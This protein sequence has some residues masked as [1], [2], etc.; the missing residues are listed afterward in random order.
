MNKVL[1][2]ILVLLICTS[3]YS[4]SNTESKDKKDKKGYV[5]IFS[6]FRGT[7]TL[8]GL[9]LEGVKLTRT[10]PEIGK[11]DE[12]TETIYTDTNGYYEFEE[13][14]GK[15]GIMRFLP[16][17]AVIHQSIKAYYE[18]KEYLLW[19]TCKRNYEPLGELKYY[20]MEPILNK[21]MS[22]AYKEDYILVNGDLESSEDFV[23]SVN[24]DI[25]FISI[26][27]FKFPYELAL[28]E[29]AQVLAAREYEFTKEISSWFEH[30]P[31]F[32][33]QLSDGSWGDMELENLEPYIGVVIESV[34]TVDYSDHLKL[35]YFEEDNNKEFNRVTVSGGIILNV[36]D[37]KGKHIKARVWLSSAIFKVYKDRVILEVQD[38][39]F[40]I[41]SSNIDP[42]IID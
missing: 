27:D 29:Y 17:E 28:I 36:V 22:V 31:Q 40:V 35:D 7:I 18:D 34:D 24:S 21:E 32:F 6:A 11:V 42:N 39:Y 5:P 15:L 38:H 2:I 10:Y 23:Q 14:M 33:D 16:H 26:T 8:N 4:N 19:Y 12:K 41:N 37:P 25:S 9:P 30:N 20:K 13:V 1:I 3:L